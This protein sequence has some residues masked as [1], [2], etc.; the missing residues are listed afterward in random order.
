MSFQVGSWLETVGIEDLTAILYVL[1]G[2]DDFGP[3]RPAPVWSC[4]QN[5][6]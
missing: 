1:Q 6:H 2:G 4:G 3:T 5:V